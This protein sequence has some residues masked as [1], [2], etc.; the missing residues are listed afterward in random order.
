MSPGP[1]TTWIVLPYRDAYFAHRF[2]YSVRDLHLIFH[3]KES[4]P[5]DSVIAVDRPVQC[6]RTASRCEEESAERAEDRA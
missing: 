6:A 1:H 4:A 2:G 5:A 3:L